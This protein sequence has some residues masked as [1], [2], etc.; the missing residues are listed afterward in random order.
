[1]RSSSLLASGG[2]LLLG[3]LLGLGALLDNLLGN[4]L[5]GNLLHSLLDSG[6]LDGFLGDNCN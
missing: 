1:M 2:N 6:L 4:W 3:D 5:L